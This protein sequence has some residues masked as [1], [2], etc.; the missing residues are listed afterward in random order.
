MHVATARTGSF[1]LLSFSDHCLQ[2]SNSSSGG[3][4]GNGTI[5]VAGG[6]RFCGVKLRAS[7]DASRSVTYF[8]SLLASFHRNHRR[9]SLPKLS[10]EDL[11]EVLGTASW[12]V[13]HFLMT[14]QSMV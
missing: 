6:V 7:L 1:L 2:W 13:T 14:L 9:R 11:S 3:E 4:T 8:A 10:L 5:D 12:T